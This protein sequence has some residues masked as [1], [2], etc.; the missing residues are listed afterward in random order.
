MS[1][2]SDKKVK[3]Y[4]TIMNPELYRYVEYRSGEALRRILDDEDKCIRLLS[5]HNIGEK[6]ILKILSKY[7]YLISGVQLSEGIIEKFIRNNYYKMKYLVFVPSNIISRSLR[8]NRNN[9]RYIRFLNLNEENFINTND[10]Y[11][12]NIYMQELIF[13]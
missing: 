2:H 7:P 9:I 5:V 1:W 4:M 3:E 13:R 11:I 12:M 8:H 6:M 10:Q